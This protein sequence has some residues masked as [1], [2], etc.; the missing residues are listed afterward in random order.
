MPIWETTLTPYEDLRKLEQTKNCAVCHSGLV[1]AW[2]PK[3]NSRVLRCAAVLE[4]KFFEDKSRIPENMKTEVARGMTTNLVTM[5]KATML[6]RI[7]SVKWPKDMTPALRE[8]LAEVAIE[9]GLDPLEGE[10]SI[11]QGKPFVG[12]N[13]RQRKAQETGKLDGISTRPGTLEE[14][15]ARQ[16]LPDDYLSLAQVWY[17]D[18]SHPFEAWGAVHRWE[19]DKLL[20]I[21]KGNGTDPM[22]LPIVK[23]PQN[24][25]DKRAK[26]AALKEAFSLPLPSVEDIPLGAE[27]IKHYD[28]DS[29]AKDLSEETQDM[30]ECPVHHKSFKAG[31]FGPYCP[32]KV[33]GKWCSEKP[34]T[35][36]ATEQPQPTETFGEPP[37]DEP[38]ETKMEIGSD[39]WYVYAG[40]KLNISD[41]GWIDL[42]TKWY[43]IPEEKLNKTV[44][45]D[46]FKLLEPGQRL[47]LTKLMQD[48]AKEKGMTI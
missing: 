4:H 6:K 18:S 37:K 40:V 12:I 41:A 16:L 39:A 30:G 29:T 45:G 47:H 43:K 36:K 21:C 11:Y 26:A 10:L 46:N 33:D 48:K 8:V 32:T 22:S 24:H 34:Q 3:A 28:I 42:F 44:M 19:I 15:T 2:D 13:G 25:S 5:S 1:I 27:P 17:K 14:K 31:K 20:E 7:D 35:R 23:D 38:P 9:R